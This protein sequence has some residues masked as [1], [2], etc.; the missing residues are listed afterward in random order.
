MILRSSAGD[1]VDVTAE[2][3]FLPLL[4]GMLVASL[5]VVWQAGTRMRD[6]VAGM[7]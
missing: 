7:I 4:L 2:M 1:L 3:S 5:A 6:D